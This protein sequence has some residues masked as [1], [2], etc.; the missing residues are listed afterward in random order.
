[1]PTLF[2]D[3][4]ILKNNIRIT[5]ELAGEADI[6]G[7]VKGNGYGLGLCS[8]AQIL[9]ESGIEILA[10]TE[11]SDAV[12]LRNSG[13]HCDILMLS[14]LY[15]KEDI[16]TALTNYIILCITSYECGEIAEQT[17][18]ELN[19]YARCQICIDTGLSRYGFADNHLKD[20]IYTIHRMKHLCVTGIYSHFYA[21]ACKKSS[22]TMKQFER[23]TTLCDALEKENEFVGYRHI[24]ASCALLRYPETKLD[25]VRI[26]SAFL[27]RLPFPDQ[28]GYKPVGQL[29]TA[30][31][32]IRTLPAGTGIGYDHSFITSKPTTI[33]I[34]SA[35]Y[36]HGL[37]IRGNY[38]CHEF[39]H[40]P[41]YLYR[42]LKNT[43]LPKKTYAYYEKE[44]FPVLGRIGM[45][46]SI[47]DITGANL[48]IGDIVRFPVNPLYVSN[49]IPRAY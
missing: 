31:K 34:V 24:A 12:K 17:A 20:I 32:D 11:I 47:I 10:V 37:G 39:F 45:N 6:I 5:R 29:E 13:I 8:Y 28:W 27:G 36:I 25:A 3:Q 35:G 21:S 33:A 30:I 15:Q 26:G 48:S 16:V 44:P 41:R 40:L 2:I 9:A 49:S 42:L 38:S 18:A 7:V 23:F 46:S 4:N 22:H 14:P 43:L 19:I 1:M